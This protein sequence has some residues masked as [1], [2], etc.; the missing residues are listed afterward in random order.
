MKSLQD[1]QANVNW[2]EMQEQINIGFFGDN[3]GGIFWTICLC[4]NS[5]T[6]SQQQQLFGAG[7]RC[8]TSRSLSVL[9]KSPH[10]HAGKNFIN[11]MSIL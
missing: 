2:I 3:V 4:C 5:K 9:L 7:W 1:G 10:H 8:Y 11:V 6:P